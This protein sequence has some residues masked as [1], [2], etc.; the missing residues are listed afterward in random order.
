MQHMTDYWTQQE[1]LLKAWLGKNFFSLEKEAQYPTQRRAP[2][3]KSDYLPRDI[4]LR[5]YDQGMKV[6][7]IRTRLCLTGDQ[8]RSV[9]RERN[10]AE[11][12][13]P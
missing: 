8:V 3:N 10:K 6:S 4:I 5:L 2:K 7:E 1:Q 9:I 11:D 13:N 12:H